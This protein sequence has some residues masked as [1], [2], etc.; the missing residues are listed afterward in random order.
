MGKR[1]YDWERIDLVYITGDMSIKD[2]AASEGIPLRSVEARARK[3]RYAD[4]RAE[5]KRIVVRKVEQSMCRRDANAIS[6]LITATEKAAAVLEKHMDDDA[7]IYE[8]AAGKNGNNLKKL[9]TKALRN[10]TGALRDA[11]SALRFLFPDQAENSEESQGI[12][13]M[14]GRE[15][16]E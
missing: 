8:Y 7:T 1:K 10:M 9:D 16:E 14:P 4:K 5:Y 3:I 2:L 15:D 12:V 13:I 11:A 6:S